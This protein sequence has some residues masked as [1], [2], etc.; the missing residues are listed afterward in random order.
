M[1][2]FLPPFFVRFLKVF[3]RKAFLFSEMCTLLSPFPVVSNDNTS[4]ENSSS[5]FDMM[6][7]EKK[8][9]K[10]EQGS[11]KIGNEKNVRKKRKE[12][13]KEKRKKAKRKR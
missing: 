8:G 9:R 13:G 4:I 10:A 3:D 5:S 7:G 1:I 11:L 12:R 2:L 6:D